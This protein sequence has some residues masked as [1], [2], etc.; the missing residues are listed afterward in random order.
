MVNAAA[1]A[2]RVQECRRG[3]GGSWSGKW[4]NK[5]RAQGE[6]NTTRTGKVPDSLGWAR[7]VHV[8]ETCNPPLCSRPRE[9]L[10]LGTLSKLPNNF[11]SKTVNK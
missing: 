5:T 11:F 8:V 9:Q 10:S 1:M 7:D 6:E 3:C 4:A 2:G